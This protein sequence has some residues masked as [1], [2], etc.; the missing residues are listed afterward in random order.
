M[1]SSTIS[2]TIVLDQFF[3]KL[4]L[5]DTNSVHYCGEATCQVSDEHLLQMLKQL[6]GYKS[7]PYSFII[8]IEYL[9]MCK[10]YKLLISSR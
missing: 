3:H 5:I 6:I 4:Y 7:F 8:N 2:L 10:K 9:H 1:K